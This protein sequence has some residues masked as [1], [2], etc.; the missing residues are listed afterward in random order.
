MYNSH[1]K[2]RDNYPLSKHIRHLIRKPV[3]AKILNVI[4]RQ[5]DARL[6]AQGVNRPDYGTVKREYSR[7]LQYGIWSGAMPLCLK[8]KSGAIDSRPTCRPV[9]AQCGTLCLSA[10][11]Q[12]NCKNA[13]KPEVLSFDAMKSSPPAKF[14]YLQLPMRASIPTPIFFH[15]SDAPTLKKVA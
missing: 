10:C 11:Y 5:A 2:Y 9:T 4:I 6:S 12:R 15:V 7:C 3:S 14:L 1:H 13:L 8:N